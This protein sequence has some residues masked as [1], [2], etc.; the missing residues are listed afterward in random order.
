MSDKWTFDDARR[1]PLEDD[2]VRVS[3]TGNSPI[4]PLDDGT[5]GLKLRGLRDVTGTFSGSLENAASIL[6][7]FDEPDKPLTMYLYGPDPNI[8]WWR[9]WFYRLRR[10]VRGTPYPS[11]VLAS[12]PA[13]MK[14]E[15]TREDDG[16][17]VFEGSFTKAGEWTFVHKE[18]NR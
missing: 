10:V 5:P 1:Y 11:I 2:E 12:G 15:E 4:E 8:R 3:M 14:L 16:D 17:V 18:V 9:D 13:T 7:A 6:S